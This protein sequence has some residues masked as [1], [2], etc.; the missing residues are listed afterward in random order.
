MTTA[1]ATATSTPKEE[2]LKGLVDG[3][4][5]STNARMS[6]WAKLLRGE[7]NLLAKS[8]D[9]EHDPSETRDGVST[10]T[11]SE[12]LP[13]TERKTKFG[14]AVRAA[15]LAFRR[16][17]GRDQSL[18][19]EGMDDVSHGIP[20][21]ILRERLS[22]SGGTLLER[23][24]LAVARELEEAAE[25]VAGND[26]AKLQLDSDLLRLLSFLVSL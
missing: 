8:D 23:V 25:E 18:E 24:K 14:G 16:E 20:S 1:T 26:G 9:D 10:L 7:A 6:S 22:Q 11:R 15:R 4:N 13:E 19:R 21:S 17:L 12:C 5:T 3:K 2:L